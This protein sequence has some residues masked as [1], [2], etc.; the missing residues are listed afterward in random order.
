MNIRGTIFRMPNEKF[1]NI[2]TDEILPGQYLRVPEEQLGKYAF[3]GIIDGFQDKVQGY[4]ILVA[5]ENMG[6]GSSREQAPKALL[7][8]GIKLIIAPS[9]GYIFYRNAINIGLALLKVTN[10]EV[11]D[12]LK[13]D[14]K[15]SVDL[16]EG[17]ISFDNKNMS[18]KVDRMNN[19][20]LKI[21]N[22]GGL[23]QLLKNNLEVL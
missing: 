6:C 4:N 10:E 22:C 18:V 21:L 8:C 2:N 13:L 9:F 12:M 23:M 16:S 11:L 5:G 20:Q 17:N 15:I 1:V 3:S 19:T 14:E 7:R